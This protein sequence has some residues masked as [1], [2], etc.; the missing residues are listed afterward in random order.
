M[1]KLYY[2]PDSLH[3]QRVA[4]ALCEK[5][6]PY[7]PIL[8]KRPTEKRQFLE[9]L[10]QSPY[11]H[12]PALEDG[13]F[14]LYESMAIIRYIEDTNPGRPLFPTD[15][16]QRARVN[17][18]IQICDRQFAPY[19]ELMIVA[20]NKELHIQDNNVAASEIQ[21]HLNF[22]DRRLAG[23]DYLVTSS[24]TMADLVY[25]PFLQF[26][27]RIKV[28]PSRIVSIWSKRILARPSALQAG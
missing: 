7:K 9:N 25:I 14:V 12:P 2:D 15:L 20:L 13:D 28:K 27:P 21:K 18:F 10:H 5:G 11:G 24:F 1:L 4:V 6:I 22:L 23:R 17:M 8:I 19:V 3:S 26:L 16:R